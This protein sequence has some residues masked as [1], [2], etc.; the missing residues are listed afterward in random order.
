MLISGD[1]DART[2]VIQQWLVDSGI[3]SRII[4]FSNG[5]KTLEFLCGTGS[6][7]VIDKSRSYL[8]LLDVNSSA[9]NWFELVKKIKNSDDIRRI[10]VFMLASFNDSSEV[11]E[12]YQAGCNMCI[13]RPSGIDD[14]REAVKRLGLFIQ[15]VKI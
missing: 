11:D 5:F 3:N 6:G 14:L 7:E 4:R 12:C 10:P 15:I 8:L 13:N 9:V 2:G 1:N